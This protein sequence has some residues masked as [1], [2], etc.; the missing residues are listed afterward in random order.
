MKQKVKMKQRI[1]AEQLNELTNEQKERLKGWWQPQEGD[2]VYIP[3]GIEYGDGYGDWDE[4]W[5]LSL[6]SRF[7]RG[8]IH[9]IGGIE[10][11]REES[12]VDQ[13]PCFIIPEFSSDNYFEIPVRSCYPLLSAGQMIEFLKER[14]ITKLG[15]YMMSLFVPDMNITQVDKPLRI[16]TDYENIRA[17]QV[18]IVDELWQAIK[19][20]L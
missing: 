7:V 15:K 13:K 10:G 11:I 3:K 20:V 5:G 12:E 17:N 19:E 1:T 4:G 18:E 16:N 14:D 2:C 8:E 6:H 9:Y